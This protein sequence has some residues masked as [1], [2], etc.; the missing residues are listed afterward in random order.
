[1]AEKREPSENRRQRVSLREIAREAGL[2]HAT[3]SM[4]LRNHP[5]I[6]KTT[7]ERVQSLARSL[8]YRPDPML[9]ALAEYR[10]DRRDTRYQATLAWINNYPEPEKLERV[11]DFLAYRRG[12]SE[13]AEELGY[14][15]EVFTPAAS[16][17]PPAKLRKILLARSIQ[18]MLLPPQPR[19][20]MEWDFDFGDFSAVAFGFSLRSPRLHTVANHQFH[21]SML[22]LEKLREYGHRRIGFA[23]DRDQNMRSGSSFLGGYLAGQNLLP[24][25]ER[26]APL[27]IGRIPDT[28]LIEEVASWFRKYKP[29]AVITGQAEVPRTL[30]AHGLRIPE[31]IALAMLAAEDSREWARVNQNSW[32]IGRMAVDMLIGMIYRNERGVP[33]MPHR[34]FIEGRW[35]DGPSAVRRPLS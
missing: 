14:K 3:V 24:P 18:G 17:I 27:V 9:K 6:A 28:G 12:A 7:R 5:E 31:D 16:G 25:K 4:A 33:A 35:M 34:V 10:K 21:S 13:R 23:I 8:G 19:W 26:V 29:D 15:L 30:I 22:A 20:G 2:S 32:E 1:M 11:Y